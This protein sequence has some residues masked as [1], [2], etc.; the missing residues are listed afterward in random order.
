MGGGQEIEFVV[1]VESPAG[2]THEARVRQH[3]LPAQLQQLAQHHPV[4][5]KYDP[6]DPGTALLVNW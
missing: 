1:S 6:D 5:V 2:G 3:M 4:T